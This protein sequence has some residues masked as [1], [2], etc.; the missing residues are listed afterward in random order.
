[1]FQTNDLEFYFEKISQNGWALLPL[2]ES[3]LETLS[4]EFQF[5]QIHSEFKNAKL[6][7]SN[8]LFLN[9]RND[10]TYWLNANEDQ[11]LSISEK[12]ILT[13][14]EELQIQLKTYFRIHLSEVECHY[15]RY[16][17]GHFYKKHFDTTL[18]NN[19]RQFSFVIYLNKNWKKSDEGHLIGYAENK[20]L[21]QVPPKWG[22]MILFRSNIEH[23]V[24]PTQA[25]RL[26]LTGWFRS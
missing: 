21:F 13:E 2:S 11:S 1:M 23:E 4:H 12:Q 22:Q 14:L 18:E 7:H 20:I 15:A 19:R 16:P 6:T 17:V 9:I 25:E 26:S 10:Q 5:R 3:F 8:D 24:E